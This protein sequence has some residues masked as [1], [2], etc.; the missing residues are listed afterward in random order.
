MYHPGVQN[1]PLLEFATSKCKW[2]NARSGKICKINLGD[3]IR[4]LRGLGILEKTSLKA[5]E[6]GEKFEATLT[7][8]CNGGLDVSNPSYEYALGYDEKLQ[9]ELFE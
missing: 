8:L 1:F 6:E 7:M 4:L 5:T 9:R 3:A 2:Y